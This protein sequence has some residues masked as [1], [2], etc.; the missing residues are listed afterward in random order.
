MKN[1]NE[2]VLAAA[3]KAQNVA[4]NTDDIN[5]KI[6]SLCEARSHYMTLAKAA[7]VASDAKEFARHEANVLGQLK[8]I[9]R[10]KELRPA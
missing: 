3:Y 10:L 5:A 8:A 1:I 2:I 9:A 7:A 4:R 6:A